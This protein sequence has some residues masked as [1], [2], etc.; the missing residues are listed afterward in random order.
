MNGAMAFFCIFDQNN[1]FK[2]IGGTLKI[3]LLKCYEVLSIHNI[4]AICIKTFPLIT[5]FKASKSIF[6]VILQKMYAEI[7]P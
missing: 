5:F 3:R 2:G 1:Q 7:I 4:D 6:N